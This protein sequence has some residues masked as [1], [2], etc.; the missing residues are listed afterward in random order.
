MIGIRI[1]QARMASGFSMRE[2]A[3][4]ANISAMAISKYENNK[5]IPSSNVLIGLSKALGVRAEYFFRSEE[6]ELKNVEYRKHCQL[7]KKTQNQ[8]EGNLIEQLERYFELERFLPSRPIQEFKVPKSIPKN[9]NEYSDIEI[10][11]H[12][13]RA[14]WGLGLNPIAEMTDMLEEKG[15]QV[16]QSSILHDEK[17]D[18]LS[19]MVD[20]V[21]VVVVGKGWKGDRQRFTLG[22]ELGHFVLEGRIN[23][24]KLDIEKAANR[25]AGAFLAPDVEVRKELGEK[26]SWLEPKELYVLKH[27]YGLS[28]GGWLHRAQELNIISDQNYQKMVRFFRDNGW[29]IDEPGSQLLPEKPQLFEQLVFRALG[30]ELIGESKAAELMGI[31]VRD[32]RDIRRNMESAEELNHK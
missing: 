13:L 3:R 9:I 15:I 21:P 5:S 31:S 23:K 27:A 19:V 30:E 18:G 28:M 12:K 29:H 25:F 22:H 11:A 20:S 16:F 26:R 6:I 10:V 32:F 8:I 24:E 1:K 7:P 2:L 14:A 4:K 17:F